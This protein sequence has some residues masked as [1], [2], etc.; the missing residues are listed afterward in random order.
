MEQALR[1]CNFV[2]RDWFSG[3]Y[4]AS[5]F[6]KATTEEEATIYQ[7]EYELYHYFRNRGSRDDDDD[8]EDETEEDETEDETE[9][10]DETKTEENETKTEETKTEETK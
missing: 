1:K 9:E 2:K 7:H 6:Y 10:E 4:I 3:W 8:T 5:E